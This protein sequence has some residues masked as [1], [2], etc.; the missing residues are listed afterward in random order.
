MTKTYDLT[1]RFIL[2]MKDN[3]E[4][5]FTAVI[6]ALRPILT[7]KYKSNPYFIT[8]QVYTFD[9]IFSRTILQ[10]HRKK[11]LFNPEKGNIVTY[12]Y[13]VFYNELRQIIRKEQKYKG[14]VRF[15]EFYC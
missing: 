7:T 6:D 5:A 14:T 8:Q 15:D 1:S 3:N 2:Y 4:R 12:S 11:H 9:D 13:H 10:L